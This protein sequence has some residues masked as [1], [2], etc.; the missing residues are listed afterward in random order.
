M[1]AR[2][3]KGDW[4]VVITG[5]DKGKAGKVLRVIPSD[6]RL[7]VEGINII[8]RHKRP[9]QNS[10]G[11]IIKR[12]ATLDISNVMHV[13][14]QSGKSTRIRFEERDGKKVRLAKRSGQLIN[15]YLLAR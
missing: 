6:N 15:T 11:G 3:R 4:V 13:D 7:V 1:S 5:R 2:I 9:S 14:P 12:E 10:P 8:K